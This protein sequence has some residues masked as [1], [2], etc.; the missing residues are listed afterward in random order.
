MNEASMATEVLFRVT[1]SGITYTFRIAEAII[2]GAQ[3]ISQN[4]REKNEV[5]WRYLNSLENEGQGT[6]GQVKIEEM[7]RRGEGLAQ[8]NIMEKDYGTF[9]AAAKA[10][11]LKY[12]AV[13]LDQTH[14]PGERVLT[15]FIA[16]G[17]AF[18]V[19]NIFELNNLNSVKDNDVMK[20]AEAAAKAAEQEKEQA[21]PSRPLTPEEIKKQKNELFLARLKSNDKA[22]K[23][24]AQK[25][26]EQS[27]EKEE[28]INPTT[29]ERTSPESASVTKSG[30]LGNKEQE[31]GIT[32]KT[33]NS[34]RPSIR[35]K[36]LAYRAEMTE[37]SLSPDEKLRRAQEYLNGM[38]RGV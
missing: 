7:L 15:I 14:Q 32:G 17:D 27:Q 21:A 4:S 23:E 35:A 20:E 6:P 13:S 37:E 33:G 2:N 3:R 30:S 26:T 36:I 10:A 22:P 34:D 9:S 29:P 31:K 24:Q 16:R 11:G 19:Q 38:N 18:T 5:M 28:V 8:V 12:A 1:L 25:S